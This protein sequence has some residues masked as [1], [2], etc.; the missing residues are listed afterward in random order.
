[1]HIVLNGINRVFHHS[2]DADRGSQVIDGITL[3][4]DFRQQDFIPDT[5]AVEKEIGS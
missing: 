2:L 5:S 3:A 1:M 4:D